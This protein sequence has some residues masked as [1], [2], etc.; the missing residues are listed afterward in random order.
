[1]N[2]LLDNTSE[3]GLV[4]IKDNFVNMDVKDII[5]KI[6]NKLY[7]KLCDFKNDIFDKK[8]NIDTKLI[9]DHIKIAYNK[10]NNYTDDIKVQEYVDLFIKDIYN[11]KKEDTLLN[12]NLMISSKQGY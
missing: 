5:K 4:Y 3:N 6:M 12:Y 11:K 7:N 9:E 8:I 10:Y 2:V 1:M